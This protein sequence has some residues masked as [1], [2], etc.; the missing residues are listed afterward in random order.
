MS[1][2][3][4]VMR[5]PK[6]YVALGD[7]YAAGPGI[8][9]PRIDSPGCFR[10]TN[11]YPARLAAALGVE[12]FTDAS[13]SGAK[14]DDMTAAQTLLL[15]GT[16]TNPPQFTALRPDTDL[17]TVTISGNDIGFAEILFACATVSATDPD[18]NPCQRE[19]TR[20]D[21]DLNAQRIAAVAPKVASVLDGIHDRSPRATVLLVGY[22]RVLPPAGGCYPVVPIA[23]GD[24]PYLD[25]V[26]QQLTDMLAGEASHHHAVFVNSYAHSLGHDVCQPPLVKWVEGFVP[27]RGLAAPVHPN[28][29]G[30]L[31]VADFARNALTDF[32][33]TAGR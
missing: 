22:L 25:G 20:G 24:V 30:M 17:V 14:T 10:S 13:C 11:N 23:R 16:S 12:D 8:P 9:N 19:Y 3:A 18:G 21:S 5:V 27:T 26:E 33:E 31:A 15:P 6:H 4:Q 2:V 7:S 28:A 32:T 29:I 1:A